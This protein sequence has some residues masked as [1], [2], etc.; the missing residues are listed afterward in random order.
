LSTIPDYLSWSF[1]LTTVLAVFFFLKA[2]GFS[3]KVFVVIITWLILHGVLGFSGFYQNTSTFPPRIFLTFGPIIILFVFLFFSKSGKKWIEKLDL[4]TL[5]ILHIVRIPVE[6]VLYGLF[7][8][9]A[10][11]E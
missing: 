8:E 6:L 5:T 11:P 4:M 3:R 9:K 1:I 10:I 7:L 2:S